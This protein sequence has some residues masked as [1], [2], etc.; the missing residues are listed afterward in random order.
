MAMRE[1]RCLSTAEVLD[2]LNAAGLQI[3]DLPTTALRIGAS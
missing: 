1:E 2:T 3:G